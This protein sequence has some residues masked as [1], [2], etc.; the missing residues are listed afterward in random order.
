MKTTISSHHRAGFGNQII[1]IHEI[2]GN[3]ADEERAA[4]LAA[5][6]FA[7]RHGLSRDALD[8]TLRMIG[9]KPEP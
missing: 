4:G 7:V 2:P 5:A 8:E 9:L 6:S 3:T 1:P